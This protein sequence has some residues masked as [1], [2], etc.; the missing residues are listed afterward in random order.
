MADTITLQ[1]LHD[2]T[3]DWLGRY[4][5]TTPV[6]LSLHDL[7][8]LNEFKLYPITRSWIWETSPDDNHNTELIVVLGC[9]LY[10]GS[11]DAITS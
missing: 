4:P 6:R 7:E 10:S 5:G 3:V 11:V 9:P 8:S 1:E 2:K